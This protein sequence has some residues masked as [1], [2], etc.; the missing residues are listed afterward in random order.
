MLLKLEL[1]TA[2]TGVRNFFKIKP[3]IINV[4]LNSMFPVCFVALGRAT[5]NTEQDDNNGNHQ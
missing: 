3:N 1:A 2:K 4:R 5:Y